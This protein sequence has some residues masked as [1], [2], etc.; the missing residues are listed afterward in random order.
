MKKADVILT[1]KEVQIEGDLRIKNG[2]DLI[3]ENTKGKATAKLSSN[4]TLTLGDSTAP[5]HSHISLY[6][7]SGRTIISDSYMRVKSVHAS[8]LN[9]VEGQ[10]KDLEIF[11]WK[12]EEIIPGKI[13]FKGKSNTD[14]L[15]IDPIKQDIIFKDGTTLKGILG[16]SGASSSGN[17]TSNANQL[18]VKNIQFKNGNEPAQ[19]LFESGTSNPDK[20]VLSHSKNF[21]N[22]GLR[23]SDKKDS[24]HFDSNGKGVLNVFLGS[25]KVGIGVE[26]PTHELEVNGS[27]AGT[28]AYKTLSDVAFKENVESIVNPIE[29]I[30]S[31][32]GVTY[33]WNEKAKQTKNVEH[34]KQYGFIA[35]EVE[36]IV[37]EL[38]STDTNGEK[39]LNYQGILPILVEAIK[40]QQQMINELQSKIIK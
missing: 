33:D 12:N 21:S 32:N 6:G 28:Q 10:I 35:Q 22:W 3:I 14:L 23:Y 34:K 7:K 36:K 4:G 19:Y 1:D 27:I 25:K 8:K 24:F 13:V 17:Q 16:Q 31:L 9:G 29:A 26:N 11:G 39:S 5:S 30:S 37:P 20:M 15:V 38:A 40:E 18:D 2:E